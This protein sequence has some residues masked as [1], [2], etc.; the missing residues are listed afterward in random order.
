MVTATG[1]YMIMIGTA[2][3]TFVYFYIGALV[4]SYAI[5]LGTLSMFSIVLGLHLI[6]VLVE[7]YKRPSLVVFVLA[8]VLGISAIMVPI[9]N[10]QNMIK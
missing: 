9:F 10:T 4:W 2:S 3:S 5:M 6:K 1:M 8:S 7:K